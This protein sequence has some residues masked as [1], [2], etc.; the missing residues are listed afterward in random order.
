[1][2][3]LQ[4]VRPFG[5]LAY[6]LYTG[7]NKYIGVYQVLK[8]PYTYS[9]GKLGSFIYLLVFSIGLSFCFMFLQLTHAETVYN[10]TCACEYTHSLTHARMHA[11]THSL[12]HCFLLLYLFKT[13][14]KLCLPFWIG[15]LVWQDSTGW[16]SVLCSTVRFGM[17]PITECPS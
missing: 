12:T 15:W 4:L 14:F 5:F 17:V 3:K 8:K 1:M 10:C 2:L 7:K 11:R 6:I 16:R 13:S 9:H